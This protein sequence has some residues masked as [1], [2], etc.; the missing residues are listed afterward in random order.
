[1]FAGSLLQAAP[2]FTDTFADNDRTAN[3]VW[4]KTTSATAGTVAVSGGVLTFTGTSGSN[5]YLTSNW[6]GSTFANV[7]DVLTLSVTFNYADPGSSIA[8][9]DQEIHFGV[10]NNNGSALTADG[11]G[12]ASDDVGYFM[13]LGGSGSG[14]SGT[15]ISRDAGGDRW[16]GSNS[17]VTDLAIGPT[18]TGPFA[19]TSD[20]TFT[21]SITK[22]A[23]GYDFL[24]SDGTNSF[25]A[26]DASPVATTFNS[27]TM[28]WYN[29]SATNSL[30]IDSISV[31]FTAIPEPGTFALVGI[32]LGTLLIFRRRRS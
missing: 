1:L 10:G 26:S 3:P 6:A 30:N 28:G 24:L 27:V 19:S 7:G 32:A 15:A 11:T 4:Y 29:R 18:A 9:R 25:T 17:D 12:T 2:V 20:K 13:A 31:D 5:Q 21:L 14:A 16:L 8:T 22:T 23:P